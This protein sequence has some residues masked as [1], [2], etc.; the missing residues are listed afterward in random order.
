MTDAYFTAIVNGGDAAAKKF[1]IGKINHCIGVVGE[2][3]VNS[4]AKKAGHVEHIRTRAALLE[5][6]KMLRDCVF[7]VKTL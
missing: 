5:Q 3:I 2:S 1:F 4:T 7:A 6:A